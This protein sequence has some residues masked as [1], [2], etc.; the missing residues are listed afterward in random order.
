MRAVRICAIFA[1]DVRED[2]SCR[3]A[4]CRSKLSRR[5]RSYFA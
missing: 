3:D 5:R 1:E 4:V 2:D